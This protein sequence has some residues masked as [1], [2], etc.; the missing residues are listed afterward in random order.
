MGAELA[1]LPTE[2]LFAPWEAP[3]GLLLAHGV[4]L[5]HSYPRPI[6]DHAQ[7]RDVALAAYA[8]NESHQRRLAQRNQ[9]PTCCV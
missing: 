5:G 4:R 2:L 6:V 8:P 1:R 9:K 3:E 7:A